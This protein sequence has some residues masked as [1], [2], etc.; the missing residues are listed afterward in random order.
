MKKSFFVLLLLFF[1]LAIAFESCKYPKCTETFYRLN[2]LAI[3][4]IMTKTGTQWHE[5]SN[6]NITAVDT[7][8]SSDSLLMMLRFSSEFYTQ[9][10]SKLDWN[11]SLFP[12]ASAKIVPCRRG[13]KGA[14]EKIVDISISSDND[15]DAEHL[16]NQSLND[17][18]FVLDNNTNLFQVPLTDYLAQI[19]AIE[20]QMDFN[21]T[22]LGQN[23]Y[24]LL[25]KRPLSGTIHIF[26]VSVTYSDG[27]KF[28]HKSPQILFL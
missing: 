2:E 3:V 7:I 27:R 8:T 16:K 1:A 28:T 5:F 13:G 9:K 6:Q 18:F 21:D 22:L 20:T 17:L 11:F 23:H 26:T 12:T 19:Y 15:F 14:T 24:I 10:E 25:K 4:R